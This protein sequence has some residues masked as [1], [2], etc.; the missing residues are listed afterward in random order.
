MTY[1]CDITKEDG[2]FIVRFPDM[3]NAIT[4]GYS[5]E[6]ALFMAQEVL[7]GIL[8]SHL[9]NGFPISEPKYTG[10][11]PIEVS[12]KVAFAISV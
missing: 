2:K 11:F 12:P 5:Q 9:E 8:T 6:E 4:I 1:N 10:G 3:T 7:N